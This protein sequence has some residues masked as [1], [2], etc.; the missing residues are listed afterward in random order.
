M[1]KS[2]SKAAVN[3]EKCMVDGSEREQERELAIPYLLSLITPLSRS[4]G[5][6]SASKSASARRT[7]FGRMLDDRCWM[8]DERKIRELA[9]SLPFVTHHSSRPQK[10]LE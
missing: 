7:A 1:A 5:A 9:C 2:G 10:G 6:E 8:L 4:R 3:G